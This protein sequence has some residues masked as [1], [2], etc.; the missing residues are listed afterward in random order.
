MADTTFRFGVFK[1]WLSTGG[2]GWVNSYEAY[3]NVALNIEDPGLFAM[4]N[5][6]AQA[7]RQIHTTQVFVDRV[8]ISTWGPDSTPYNPTRLRVVPISENGLRIPSAGDRLDLNA[9]LNV[10]REVEYG[11]SGKLAFRGVLTE[12]DV[13][14]SAS[15]FWQLNPTSGVGPAGATWGAYT[16]LISSYLADTGAQLYLAMLGFAGN[17]PGI[18]PRAIIGHTPYG[19]GFNRMNHRHYDR[20]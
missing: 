9:V 4:A 2:K 17:P 15:G 5:D 10:R 7:E 12:D 8:V 11:R 16:N 19:A 6:L 14:A 3:S 20:P 18:T 13:T 1:N